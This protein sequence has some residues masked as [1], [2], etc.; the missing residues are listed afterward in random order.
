[1]NTPALKALFWKECRENV[2]WAVLAGLALSLGLTYTWYRL[3][4]QDSWPRFSA[5][6]DNENLVLTIT[7]PLIGLALGLL[8]ILPELRR[9]QWAFLVHRPVSHTTLFWGKVLPGIPLLGLSLGF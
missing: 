1:M 9:D 2:R 5:I 8:Q 3:Y 6:W 7:M 4:Q